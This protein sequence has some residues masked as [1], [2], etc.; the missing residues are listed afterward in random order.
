VHRH[1]AVRLSILAVSVGVWLGAQGARAERDR[2]PARLRFTSAFA[3]VAPDGQSL[4]WEGGVEGATRGRARLELR[5]VEGPAEAANPVWHVV[6]HW[7]V[8][9]ASGT[10]SFTAELEGMIDWRSGTS[11][12]G[13]VIT[14]GWMRGAWAQQ[15]GR[16]VNGDVSGSLAINPPPTRP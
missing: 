1:I 6:A 12:L 10:R 3:G 16:F 2:S 8:T 13:G 4:V 7:T 5:Q 14:S 11:R 15:E 9:D